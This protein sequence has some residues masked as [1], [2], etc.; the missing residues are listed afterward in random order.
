MIKHPLTNEKALNLFSFEQFTDGS[1]PITVED[2]MR[3]AADWQLDQAFEWLK[4]N[5]DDYVFYSEPYDK[6]YFLTEAFL[7]DFK[8]AMRPQEDN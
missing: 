8:K 5:T 2:T 6:A 4:S 1:P 7:D 3:T